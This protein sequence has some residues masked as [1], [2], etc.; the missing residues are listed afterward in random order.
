VNLKNVERL[1]GKSLKGTWY[2]ALQPQ[3]YRHALRTEHTA[4]L[5]SR[6]NPGNGS[7]ETLYLAESPEVALFEVGA[8]L[9]SPYFGLGSLIVREPRR[10][11]IMTEVDVSLHGVAELHSA[12]VQE[13]LD[14]TAQMLTGDWAGYQMRR[15]SD[16]VN[17]PRGFAPTQLLGEALYRHE[18][19]EA[20]TTV[21][22]RVP[23]RQ[24]LII[25]P[26]KVGTWSQVI[27]RNPF[28]RDRINSIS[29]G[30]IVPPA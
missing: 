11:W 29:G 18:P 27:F 1:N 12:S 8:L 22:A 3:Y 15:D 7:F 4:A 20:F 13:M 10:S 2:R 19:I 24:S 26:K 21:P 9:G 16:S 23:T 5:P 6:F 17:S 14:V 30:E 28:T 25:F